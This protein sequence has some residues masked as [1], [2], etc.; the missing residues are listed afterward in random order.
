MTTASP[1]GK[2]PD[3][4]MLSPTQQAVARSLQN[5]LKVHPVVQLSTPG[6]GISTG[7]GITTLLQHMAMQHRKTC[8]LGFAPYIGLSVS[9]PVKFTEEFGPGVTALFEYCVTFLSRQL[10]SGAEAAI[11]FVDD[12]DLLARPSRIYSNRIS[13]ESESHGFY[14]TSSESTLF[15][16]MLIDYCTTINPNNRM[17]LVFRSTENHFLRFVGSPFTV[18]HPPLTPRDYDFFLNLWIPL[19]NHKLAKDGYEGYDSSGVDALEIHNQFPQLSPADIRVAC[20]PPCVDNPLMMTPGSG[21]DPALDLSMNT[22]DVMKNIYNRL[23]KSQ[24][25]LTLENVERVDLDKM[26]GLEPVVELLETH[27]VSPMHNADVAAKLGAEPKAGVLLY[28]PPGTGKTSVGRWLA[29]RL[30][31]KV[32]MM[33]EMFVWKEMI[34]TFARAEANAPSVVFIDDIDVLLAKVKVAWGGQGD[35]FRFILGKLDGLAS[36]RKNGKYVCVVMACNDLRLL[37]EALIRSGRVE[38]WVKTERP[39]GKKRLA[40]LK[41]LLKNSGSG[42]SGSSEG[43][44]A[45]DGDEKGS[46]GEALEVEDK[47]LIEVAD[48]TEDWNASDI[49]RL[50]KDM[51]NLIV[52]QE[53]LGSQ[54]SETMKTNGQ[55]LMQAYKDMKK[56][57]A[58]VELFQRH[59]YT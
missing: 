5:A 6:E 33:K 28:G 38:L 42:S 27:V 32:F 51:R 1:K 41:E 44:T 59:M 11:I 43:E 48:R 25:A 4:S 31:G 36:Y 9:P 7:L 29:H 14:K 57:I 49:R 12:V 50:V 39:D 15:I 3:Q 19:T 46:E 53:T 8:G 2:H 24:G 52:R 45:D 56:M 16:K 21:S 13:N 40:M 47:V 23:G 18:T 20:V 34:E 10:Q 30:K 17:K 26:P 58:D 55:L 22:E 54:S 37:P 35:I